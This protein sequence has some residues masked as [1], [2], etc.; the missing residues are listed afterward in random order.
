MEEEIINT[1]LEN[2]SYPAKVSGDS[3][4][5]GNNVPDRPVLF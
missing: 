2:A 3:G 1:I 5:Q 4:N